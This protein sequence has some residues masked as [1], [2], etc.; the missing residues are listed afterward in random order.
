[1]RSTSRSSTALQMLVDLQPRQRAQWSENRALARENGPEHFRR[2]GVRCRQFDADDAPFARFRDLRE[3]RSAR[4]PVIANHVG[5][6]CNAIDST[7]SRP[8]VSVMRCGPFCGGEVRWRVEDS[9]Y[10]RCPPQAIARWL[11]YVREVVVFAQKPVLPRPHVEEMREVAVSETTIEIFA[12]R[13]RRVA[14][15]F[16][17]EIPQGI[18][19]DCALEMEMKLDLWKRHKRFAA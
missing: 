2:V 5:D 12:R 19:R 8:R 16:A 15:V 4:C 9:A 7:R 11:C 6:E 17:D 3:R 18:E 10:R 14:A 1:M 13:H